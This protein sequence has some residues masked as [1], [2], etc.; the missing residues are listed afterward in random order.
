MDLFDLADRTA[1]S[2]A[3]TLRLL[4]GP[5]RHEVCLAY[6]IARLTDTIADA[7]DIGAGE[8]LDLLQS[9]ESAVSGESRWPG[10]ELAR[11]AIHVPNPGEAELLRHAG[12]LEGFF[13]RQ[14]SSARGRAKIVLATIISGQILDIE[15]FAIRPGSFIPEESSLFDYTW[16]VAGCVGEFWTEVLAHNLPGCLKLPAEEL[17]V[18]GKHYG[19]GLQ[20]LNILRDAPADWRDGRVYL[21]M[22][23]GH[24]IRPPD[25]AGLSMLF[26]SMRGHLALCRDW[27][28]DGIRY[29]EALSGWRV[30][31]ASQLPAVL[32]HLTLDMLERADF[33]AWLARVKVRR[34]DVRIALLQSIFRL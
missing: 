15:R 13:L 3:L 25:A 4:P 33:P 19:Q 18:L 22:P 2:F 12:E 32:G 17:T 30:R 16:R 34:A 10:A 14:D 29:C 26:A 7:T 9:V 23:A 5:V 27:L 1:R 28:D 6:L 24:A 8:R 11:I 31:S 20:L 21:P